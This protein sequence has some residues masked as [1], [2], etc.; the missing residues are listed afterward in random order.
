MTTRYAVEDEATLDGVA[1]HWRGAARVFLQPIAAPS[2]LGLFALAGA[3]FV[4]AGNLAGWYGNAGSPDLLFPF[5]AVF[6][7]VAQLAAAMCAYRVRDGLATAMHGIWRSFWAAYGLLWA[8]DAAGTVTVPNGKFVELGFWFIAM[9]AI[10]GSAR[11]LR[12]PRASGFSASSRRSRAARPCLRSATSSATRRSSRP[13][14]SAPSQKSREDSACENRARQGRN[15]R[16]D[17][18]SVSE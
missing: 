3:T 8:L 17:R 11:P 12:W 1:S 18:E 4:T 2:I 7:G 16:A 6:G 9:A 15:E 5:V 14:A 10:G 13:A